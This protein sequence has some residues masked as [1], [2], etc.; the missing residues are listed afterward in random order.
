MTSKDFFDSLQM[1]YQSQLP[2]VAYSASSTQVVK[3]ILQKDNTLHYTS[4]FNESGFVFAPFDHQQDAILFPIDQSDCFETKAESDFKFERHS[5]EDQLTE[6]DQENHMNLVLKGIF[7]IENDELQKVVL[8]RKE[9]IRLHESNPIIIFQQLLSCYPNAFVYCWYHP[10]I[11]LWLGATP[12]TLL[13]VKG[14][15]FS[16]M[17]LAG[18]Q[19]YQG[20]LDVRWQTKELEEQKIVTDYLVDRLGQLTENLQATEVQTIRAAN[21]LHLKTD[22]LGTLDNQ[23]VGLKN[24][25]EALHPTPAVSGFP[26]DSAKQFILKNENYNREFY[27]GFLGAINIKETKPRNSNRRNVEN[28]AYATVKA[29][30]NLY[31]NLRCM[32]LKNNY[33]HI[34]VGGG[35]TKDSNSEAE[36][37]ETVNKAM[38]IKNCL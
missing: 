8:S 28:N 17:A 25:L 33:A 2:F 23:K 11:G 19:T 9:T 14:N 32:Q 29:V 16:T 5:I 36:W 15:R 21:V 22:I 34:Y 20:T 7:A 6:E 10:K 13:K 35:I 4:E 26:K 18:T 38:T 24:I 31:V 30:S 1:H 37:Y 3:S 27:T 12:E